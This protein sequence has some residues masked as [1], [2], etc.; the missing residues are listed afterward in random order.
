MAD[1]IKHHFLYRAF[2]IFAFLAGLA[3][4][5]AAAALGKGLG[6][7]AYYLLPAR[8][9][10]ALEN[11]AQCPALP[12]GINRKKLARD[13]FAHLGLVGTEFVKFYNY[14]PEKIFSCVE[15]TGREHLSA[16]LQKGKGAV[17]ISS[18]LGNWELMG[19][20][21]AVAGYP[22]RPLVKKQKNRLFDRLINEKRRS[23]GMNPLPV[24]FTLREIIRALN[25]NEAVVFLMDQHAGRGGVRTEFLGREASVHRGPAL[26]ALKTGVPVVPVHIIRMALRRH[27][28]KILPPVEIIRTGNKE[29]EIRKNTERFCAMLGEAIL[30]APEQWLWMHRRWRPFKQKSAE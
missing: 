30:E 27:R 22:L 12:A 21:L 11:I 6:R 24:G 14:T 7:L 23:V 25:R 8:R 10:T 28:I 5:P 20:A 16:V 9:K 1:K 13:S 15:I 3:P 19:M 2:R 4:F 17:I 29:E 18:H 26:V